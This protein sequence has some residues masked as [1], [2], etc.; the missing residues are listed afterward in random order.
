MRL[1]LRTKKDG[2]LY[3]NFC[4]HYSLSELSLAA[5]RILFRHQVLMSISFFFYIF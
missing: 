5:G 4:H 3:D 2:S 1:V